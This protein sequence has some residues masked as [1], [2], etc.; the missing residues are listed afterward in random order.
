[1][2]YIFAQENNLILIEVK[3]EKIINKEQS[4]YLEILMN[5]NI[6]IKPINH[7]EMG[8]DISI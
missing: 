6:H 2:N 1:M 3:K 4:I 5:Y 8:E 7:I